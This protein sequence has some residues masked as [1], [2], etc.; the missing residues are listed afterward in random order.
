MDA[1]VTTL[2]TNDE[3]EWQAL[4]REHAAIWGDGNRWRTGTPRAVAC[5]PSFRNRPH[6]E[7]YGANLPLWS[8]TPGT[9]S[10]A[11]ATY[12]GKT[13][14]VERA[15]LAARPVTLSLFP[16][17]ARV[18]ARVANTCSYQTIRALETGRHTAKTQGEAAR[19]R[20]AVVARL[21]KVRTLVAQLSLVIVG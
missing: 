13:S 10:R 12:Y 8:E 6:P 15:Q 3:Q 19:A 7:S 16:E 11:H 1:T 5:A 17:E 9:G 20:E 4:E 18:A 14:K 2:T 21:E